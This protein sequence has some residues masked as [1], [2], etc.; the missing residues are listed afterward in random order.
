METGLLVDRG[1]SSGLG[2]AVTSEGGAQVKLE[3]L[4]KVV[5]R[6]ESGADEVGGGPCLGED[7]TMRLVAVLGLNVPI[8]RLRLLVVLSR[9]LERNVRGRGGLDLEVDVP[10]GV[11]LAKQI[12]G[13]LAEI[14]YASRKSSSALCASASGVQRRATHL[15]GRGNGLRERHGGCFVTLK[16]KDVVILAP[17]MGSRVFP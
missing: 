16:S 1:E 2:T 17:F 10:E 12:A 11:V 9:D 8:N 3:T 7:E 4:G 13:G 6:L 14:L 5:L 15:P